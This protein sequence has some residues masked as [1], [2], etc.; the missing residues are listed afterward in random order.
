MPGAGAESLIHWRQTI[1][2]AARAGIIDPVVVADLDMQIFFNSVEWPAIRE[3]V[4]S[5][6][7][8]AARIIEWEHRS[9]GI[10]VLPSGAEFAFDRGAEQGEPLGSVKA[11][12]PLGNARAAVEQAAFQY[13]TRDGAR[14]PQSDG[15]RFPACD[16]WYIDDGQ[17][18]YQ[19][20][21]FDPWVRAFDAAIARI[22]A[23]RGRGR[24]IKSVAR[25]I[26]PTSRLEE[27]AGWDTPYVLSTCKVQA[28]NSPAVALGATVGSDN[29]VRTAA[30]H[31]CEKVNT[32][33]HAIAILSHGGGDLGRWR[34]PWAVK[35]QTPRGGRRA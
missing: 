21:A 20:R 3:A 24:D 26:C 23:S 13:A 7:P 33:R 27:F 15:A 5:E 22:G 1:E 16:E 2:A 35:C 11:V 9:P 8:E 14:L 31:I 29:D 10:T 6:F 32:K 4:R 28:P 18:V 34:R 12:A 19:P 25:L 17:L 30:S